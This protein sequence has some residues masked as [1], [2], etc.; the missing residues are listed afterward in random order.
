[1]TPETT[2]ADLGDESQAA[3]PRRRVP[4]SLFGETVRQA[5]MLFTAQSGALAA[6]LLISLILARWMEPAEMGRFAFCLAI[7]I[8]GGV[9]FE[10]GFFSAGARV[11]AL[12]HDGHSQR[13]ALGALVI[14]AAVAGLAFSAFIAAASLPID[15]IF[16]KDVHWLLLGTAALAFFQP[17]QYF[18][19]LGCQGLNRIRLLAVFQLVM[20]GAYLLALVALVAAH[21]L[22][23]GLALG[24]YLAGI[25]V[26]TIWTIARLRPS[27]K[28]V[29]PYLRMTLRQAREYGVNLYFARITGMISSRADQLVIAYFL[30]DAA[31]L[32]VYAIVQKFANPI[33]M[34]GR[35]VA[36]TRFRA[37]AQLTRVPGRLTRWNAA[38]LVSAALGL[39]IIGPMVVNFLFPKYSAGVGLLVPFALANLFVGLFQPYNIFLSSHGRGAEVR[40]IAAAV[41]ISSLLGL[42]I[43]VPRYGISGAAWTAAAA[44]ALDYMLHLY[45]YQKFKR[46]LA[47]KS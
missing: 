43:A 8:V 3:S 26:A 13:R 32:G 46:T 5:G 11:L 28:G 1:M 23:A 47:Q 15:A 2:A 39:I 21:Q 37:F 44:M 7:I 33:N 9:F 20:S 38:M 6:G 14:L 10:F 41:A 17:F 42:S 22:T 40:N 34:L 18:I 19:E 45:Y 25:A 30:A 27:F 29:S 12:E 36:L 35:S 4:A 16:K 24:A 31:P